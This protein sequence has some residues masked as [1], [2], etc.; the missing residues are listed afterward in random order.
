MKYQVH[1]YYDGPFIH[2]DAVMSVAADDEH[3]AVREAIALIGPPKIGSV[4]EIR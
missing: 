1:I 2:A 4:Q 3:D